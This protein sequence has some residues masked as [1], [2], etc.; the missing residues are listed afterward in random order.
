[1]TQFKFKS[2]HIP[3]LDKLTMFCLIKTVVLRPVLIFPTHIIYTQQ[4][5]THNENKVLTALP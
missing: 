5:V 2:K 4:D 3:Q 1:M